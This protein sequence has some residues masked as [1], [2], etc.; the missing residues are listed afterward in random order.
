MKLYALTTTGQG[1]AAAETCLCD[2]HVQDEV[3]VARVRRN[4]DTDVDREAAFVDCTENDALSCVVCGAG[5]RP[6]EDEA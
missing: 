5:A 3:E 1:T 2:L 6:D 4:A